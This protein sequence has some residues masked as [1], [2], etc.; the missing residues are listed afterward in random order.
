[1]FSL[2]RLSKLHPVVGLPLSPPTRVA[3]G[4]APSPSFFTDLYGENG[5][6]QVFV[7]DLHSRRGSFG[8]L[9]GISDHGAQHLA[10]ARHLG[11]TGAGGDVVGGLC[12]NRVQVDLGLTLPDSE[13][14]AP[15][16]RRRT[17]GPSARGCRPR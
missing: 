12:L 17:C 16:R 11:A 6:W 13:P 7:A 10:N 4:S 14:A 15:P 8:A 9:P 5:L 1:M 2:N 3:Q